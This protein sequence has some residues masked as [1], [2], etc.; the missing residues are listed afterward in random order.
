MKVSWLKKN[1]TVCKF[2]TFFDFN[3]CYQDANNGGLVGLPTTLVQT[4]M[5]TTL[6]TIKVIVWFQENESY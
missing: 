5:S 3:Q 6:I 1:S 2:I 4:D